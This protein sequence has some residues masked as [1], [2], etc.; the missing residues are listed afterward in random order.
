MHTLLPIKGL[1]ITMSYDKVTQ[2]CLSLC[3]PMDCNLPVSSVHGILQ[4]RVLEWIAMPFSRASFQPR[5]GTLVSY[6][7]SRFFTIWAT[8][9]GDSNCVCVCV[10]RERERLPR[11]C[12]WWR[13][14]LPVQETWD[15]G[16]IPGSG[17]SPKRGHGATHS[18]ILAWRIPWIE[19]P[20]RLVHSATK[21]QTQL[22]W[23]SHVCV[24]VYI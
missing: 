20:S 2:S 3:N 13:T 1:I 23:L 10:E 14:H 7:K 22:K 9:E 18:S 8:R 4:T 12:Y 6:I 17:S 16:L 15:M 11:C 19:E 5:D 24:C 21:S